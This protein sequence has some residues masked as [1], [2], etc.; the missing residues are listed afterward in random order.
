M[1]R[2]TDEGV[3]E[4]WIMKN[5]V[6]TAK[7]QKAKEPLC[8]LC[9]VQF[10]DSHDCTNTK[11]TRSCDRVFYGFSDHFASTVSASSFPGRIF[12]RTSSARMSRVKNTPKDRGR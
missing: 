1:N 9:P 5:T 4:V 3:K 7:E 12:G 11:K 8:A 2:V 10:S 6:L